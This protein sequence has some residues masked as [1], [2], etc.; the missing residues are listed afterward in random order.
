MILSIIIPVFNAEKYISDCLNSCLAQD[1]PQE[2]YEII[3][4]DD[5]ST[6]KSYAVLLEYEK[7]YKNI[8]VLRHDK[9]SGKSAA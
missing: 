2:E 8:V 5:R 1:I 9:N 3:C 4:V 7:M 6:D